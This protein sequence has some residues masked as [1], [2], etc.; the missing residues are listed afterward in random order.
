MGTRIVVWYPDT[1]RT[2][3]E[4]QRAQERCLRRA[5]GS[6]SAQRYHAKAVMRLSAPCI[7]RVL[8]H[9]IPPLPTYVLRGTVIQPERAKDVGAALAGYET[10]HA[11]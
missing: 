9:L 10:I 1:Y 2:G 8:V 4:L 3:S 7:T 5:V 11:Q 6:A